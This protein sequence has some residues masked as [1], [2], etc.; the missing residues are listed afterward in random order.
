MWSSQKELLVFSMR[1][2]WFSRTY[3]RR[4]SGLLEED[5]PIYLKNTFWSS[6]ERNSRLLENLLVLNGDILVFSKAIFWPFSSGLLKTFLSSRKGPSG[7]LERDLWDLW[8][9]IFWSSW[10]GPSGLLEE[11]IFLEEEVVVP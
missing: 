8:K 7:H 10:G 4:S 6:R 1:T 9:K 2:F 3:K 5:L 11:D